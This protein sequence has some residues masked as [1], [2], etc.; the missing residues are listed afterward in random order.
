MPAYAQVQLKG[1]TGLITYTVESDGTLLLSLDDLARSAESGDCHPALEA[2]CQRRLLA[3]VVE[4]LEKRISAELSQT[5]CEPWI[6]KDREV[7]ELQRWEPFVGWGSS[8]PGHLYPTDPGR[9]TSRDQ[10]R[11]TM[12][13]DPDGWRL[14]PSVVCRD[15]WSYAIVP[16]TLRSGPTLH[17]W[18]HSWVRWRRWVPDV[19]CAD[20][21]VRP[22]PWGDHC[23]CQAPVFAAVLWLAGA[24]TLASLAPLQ[25]EHE[26]EIDLEVVRCCWGR[27]AQVAAWRQQLGVDDL[28]TTRDNGGRSR[29]RR[30]SSSDAERAL[31]PLAASAERGRRSWVRALSV[32]RAPLRVAGGVA[33]RVCGYI[34][35]LAFGMLMLVLLWR[36]GALWPLATYLASWGWPV[37]AVGCV[38][39]LTGGLLVAWLRLPAS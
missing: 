12:S 6:L 31:W 3:R 26:I 15:G 7:W 25:L 20:V 37:L 23:F 1:T 27:A 34:G 11:S 29:A 10:R 22:T 30:L 39:V 32:L 17:T 9:W 38:G 21:E 16:Q 13:F 35:S 24:S 19:P 8:Y 4:A 5:A 18:L 36:C 28:R 33:A 14:D 2:G